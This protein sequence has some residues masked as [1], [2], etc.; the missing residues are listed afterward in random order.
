MDS[1]VSSGFRCRGVVVNGE[2]AAAVGQRRWPAAF[3]FSVLFG[4]NGRVRHYSGG[5]K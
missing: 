1:K 3:F 4:G 5:V 2:R